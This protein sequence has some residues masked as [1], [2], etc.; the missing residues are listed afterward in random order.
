MSDND[1]NLTNPYTTN[2]KTTSVP[3]PQNRNRIGGDS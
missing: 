1:E 3:P 2:K